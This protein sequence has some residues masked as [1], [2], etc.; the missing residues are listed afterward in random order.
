VAKGLD[1]CVTIAQGVPCYELRFLPDRSA[2]EAVL[3]TAV[4]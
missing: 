2:V 4:H 1:A 3:A